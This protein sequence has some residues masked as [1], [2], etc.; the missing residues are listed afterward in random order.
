[1]TI[2]NMKFFEEGK[3]IS[4]IF[5]QVSNGKDSPLRPSS[6]TI[7]KLARY[8]DLRQCYIRKCLDAFNW[9]E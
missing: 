3:A 6:E 5:Y 8:L 4:R 7:A 1:M 2:N 9:A